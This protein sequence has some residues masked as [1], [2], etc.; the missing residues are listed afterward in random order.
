MVPYS[1]PKRYQPYPSRKLLENHTL[2]RGKYL[3]SPYMT[4]TPPPPRAGAFPVTIT[5]VSTRPSFF[6][7]PKGSPWIKIGRLATNRYDVWRTAE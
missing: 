7:V 2:H 6:P 3:Y 1:R 5:E 4:V